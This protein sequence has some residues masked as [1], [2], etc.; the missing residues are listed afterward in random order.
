M[1][2]SFRWYGPNDPVTLSNIRQ[3]NAEYIVTSLHQIP[4]GFKWSKNDV[5]Q[6]IKFINNQ[7]NRN[8]IN[9][10]W[11]VVESIPVHNNIKLRQKNYKKLID[12]YKDSIVN[13]AKNKIY[14]ICYNFMPI[15]DWTRTQLDYKLPTDGL[16]LRFNFIQFIIFEKYIL[17]LKDLE[18]RYNSIQLKVAEKEYKKMN[19][20]HINNLKFSIMGG[21]PAAE[22]KYTINEFKK[23]LEEF[24]YV[25]KNILRENLKEFLKEILPVA[26]DVNVKMALHPDDP[27]MP[28]F[29]LPR[30][31]SSLDDYK[32]ILNSYNSDSN[33]MT[34]CVG[35]LASSIKNDVYKIFET[36]KKKINFIHLRNIKIE[37]DRKSFYESNHISGD[38]DF[39]RVI[40]MILKEEKRRKKCNLKFNIPMRPDHGHCLLDDQTKSLNPGYSAIGRM[41]GLSEIRGILKSLEY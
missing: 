31:V 2:L 18:K 20:K 24:K 32:F 33:G 8:N 11:N 37:K 3:S 4:T 10:K 17:K 38:I 19:S 13:V 6:R 34:Y 25:N 41:M 26:E 36:L 12:N 39:I 27:P 16:A 22:K 35:S 7:N 9:L 30:I 29:G 21:L 14:T 40:K 1:E 15:I 28:L 23:M 5:S